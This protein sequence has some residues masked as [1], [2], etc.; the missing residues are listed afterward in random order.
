MQEPEAGDKLKLQNYDIFHSKFCLQ[1]QKL[2]Q[3]TMLKLF[4]EMTP[5]EP[6]TAE[7]TSVTKPC[8]GPPKGVTG[9][10]EPGK[11]T[12]SQNWNEQADR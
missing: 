8:E 3:G 4:R 5:E 7:T 10:Q 11:D 6:P 2:R 9:I 1:R 12:E